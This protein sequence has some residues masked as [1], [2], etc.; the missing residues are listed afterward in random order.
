MIY[1][2]YSKLDETDFKK[3]DFDVFQQAMTGYTQ[4]RN[5][6]KVS[7]KEILTIIDFR[8]PSNEKRLWVIDLKQRKIVYHSL[9]AHGRNSGELFSEQFSNKNNSLQSSL[10]FYLTG[11]TYIGKHG[12][13][14]KLH[15]VEAGFNDQAEN[16]HIV[17]HGADYVSEKYI[18]KV[19]RLG[20]SQGCPAVPMELHKEL[21]QHIAGNT[22]LFIYYPD[23]DYLENTTF[24]Y[25]VDT[26]SFLATNKA[27]DHK[28]TL[29]FKPM[30][31][32]IVPLNFRKRI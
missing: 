14:L 16:R 3:P 29:P 30:D 12:V 9:V 6:K 7:E 22:C 1:R 18:K 15:G 5:S 32:T 24:K 23:K 4:L 8:R 26:A 25:S 13:S 11:S 20:R 21:I 19:G 2:I 28:T 27:S 17:I 10:G 31:F